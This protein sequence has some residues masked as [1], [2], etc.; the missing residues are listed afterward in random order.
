M[1]AS[2][3]TEEEQLITKAVT[4][5]MR[6]LSPADVL[7]FLT[8]PRKKRLDSVQ[9]HRQWQAQLSKDTFFKRVFSDE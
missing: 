8:M 1:K 2:T 9:R 4:V 7:R 3:Y 5:L 6:E